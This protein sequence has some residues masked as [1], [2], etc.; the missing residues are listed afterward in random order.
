MQ[1]WSSR[2]KKRVPV[3]FEEY[4]VPRNDPCDSFVTGRRR[5]DAFGLSTWNNHETR[6]PLYTIETFSRKENREDKNGV[7]IVDRITWIDTR[8]L[9]FAVNGVG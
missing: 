5:F 8:P 6:V 7:K 2:G 9:R 4:S 3:F 1:M